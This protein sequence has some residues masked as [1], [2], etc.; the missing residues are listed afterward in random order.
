M[1]E[2]E[3]QELGRM[4]DEIYEPKIPAGLD[5]AIRLGMLKAKQQQKKSTTLKWSSL[6]AS[7]LIIVMLTSIRVSPAFAG[8]VSQIPG[9]KGIVEL[10]HN[11][12]GLTSAIE[13][14][15]YEEVN[16]TDI[17]NGLGFTVDGMIIDESR[18]VLFYTVENFSN[19]DYAMNEELHLFDSSGKR[20]AAAYTFGREHDQLTKNNNKSQGKFDVSFSSNEMVIPE[21]LIVQASFSLKDINR[22]KI[23]LQ[24]EYWEIQIPIDHSKFV[25]VKREFELNE[26]V[27]FAGQKLTFHNVTI[28]P[29]RVEVEVEFAEENT[30]KIFGFEDLR[31][32][33]EKG[34]A[35]NPGTLEFSGTSYSENYW[36]LYLESNYFTDGKELFLEATSIRALPKDELDVVVDLA[37]K[38]IVK[39]P[40]LLV[41]EEMEINGDNYYFEFSVKTTEEVDRDRIFSLFNME[42]YD[43]KGKVYEVSDGMSFRKE[44]DHKKSV[45]FTLQGLEGDYLHLKLSD[46]PSRIRDE[47]KIKL[48]K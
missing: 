45:A 8:F 20:I 21:I 30:M 12:K 5:D 42:M 31:I 39:G 9:M 27:F 7:I 26:T 37:N 17:Q 32:T 1:F 33:N 3:E 35:S 4:K 15:F 18:L 43:E 36:N 46:Y 11:D 34:E 41:L 2:K 19:I 44:G 29:T 40:E 28:F 25:D 6:A 10:I 24:N 14:D 38:T 16:I 22:K 48:T 23:P 47:M 13:N